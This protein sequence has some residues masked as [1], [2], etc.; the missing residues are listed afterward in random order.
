MAQMFSEIG[1]TLQDLQLTELGLQVHLDWDRGIELISPLAGSTATVAGSV[2]EF[3]AEHG[4]GVYTVVIR[5]PGAAAAESVAA[6][7]GATVRFRQHFDGD[8]TYLDE[9]DLSV[10]DLPLT[11]LATNVP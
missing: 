1:F 10:L 5:V 9:I 3:L 8:G 4:D 6:R 11:F 7:Y 2:R